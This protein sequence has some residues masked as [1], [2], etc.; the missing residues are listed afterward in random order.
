[1]KKSLLLAISMG[2]IL[3]WYDFG[4][5]TLFAALFARLF[6]PSYD[7]YTAI[8]A[9]FAI[10]AS[11]FVCRPLGAIL[12]GHFG[13]KIGRIRTLRFSILCTAI[14]TLLIACLPTY[15]SMGLWGALLLTLL[16][17]FQGICMGGEFTGIIIY[18]A[19]S[20]PKHRRAF[21]TSFAGTAANIGI[22]SAAGIHLLLQHFIS[23]AQLE[24]WGW[25]LAFV[26]GGV[27][28][29][30]VL[31]LRS[32]LPDTPIFDQLKKDQGPILFPLREVLK[33][34]PFELL[35]VI[36]LTAL[37]A[38][39]YYTAF[40]YIS[41]YLFQVS[42]LPKTQ[43]LEIQSICIISMLLLVPLFGC[44]CDYIG[45]RR[46]LLIIALSTLC[47]V[48]PCFRFLASGNL[49]SII[50]AM[51]ILTLISSLEQATTT[52][53]V[54][55]NFPARI[56]YSGISLGYNVGLALFGGT[57]PFIAAALMSTTHNPIAPAYYLVLAALLTLIVVLFGLKESRNHSLLD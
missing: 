32:T 5:F 57:S 2:N 53:T 33:K 43:I 45:R 22:L 44:L 17:L 13:D 12:F 9:V 10:F 18:L 23:N 41:T 27:L 36:A 52:I 3:E 54:V 24:S 30:L 14:P 29:L 50:V 40:V 31:Y 51:G 15:H 49:F 20:A 19:E 42:T 16:R 6:F 35:R 55:E 11:G 1:M 37:G 48:L 8:L 46:S 26:L 56:R 25:R 21:F 47:L 38:S 7:S 4:L 34:A 28:T 39:L